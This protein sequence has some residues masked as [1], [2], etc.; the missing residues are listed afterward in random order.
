MNKTYIK[1]KNVPS[2]L[3]QEFLSIKPLKLVQS[4]AALQISN[5]KSFSSLRVIRCN[6]HHERRNDTGH[7]F[8]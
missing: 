8:V 2:F 3:S 4:P 5:S 1:Q 7:Y 6:H